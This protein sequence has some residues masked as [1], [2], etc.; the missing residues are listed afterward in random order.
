VGGVC[1]R[2]H[3]LPRRI[4]LHQGPQRRVPDPVHAQRLVRCG[5]WGLARA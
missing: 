3:R 2:L 5:G 4:L 1:R